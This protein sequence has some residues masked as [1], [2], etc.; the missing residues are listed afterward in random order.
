[1]RN[2][3][4]NLL[5]FKYHMVEDITFVKTIIDLKKSGTKWNFLM[6]YSSYFSQ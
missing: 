5:A 1:M 2:S 3:E 4:S 6:E